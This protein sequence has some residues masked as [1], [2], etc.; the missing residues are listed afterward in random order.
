MSGAALY[1]D[2]DKVRFLQREWVRLFGQSEHCFDWECH[3]DSLVRDHGVRILVD[4][5]GQGRKRHMHTGDG[6]FRPLPQQQLSPPPQQ[7]C[8]SS[9]K[10]AYSTHE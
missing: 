4:H 6:G 7:H 5:R 1:P 10:G 3:L 2:L 8:R 9:G